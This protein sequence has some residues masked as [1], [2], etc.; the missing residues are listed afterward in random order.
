MGFEWVDPGYIF[1][2]PTQPKPDL[3][4]KKSAQ[5]QPWQEKNCLTQPYFY[6]NIY[7]KESEFMNQHVNIYLI[8]VNTVTISLTKTELLLC[9]SECFLNAAANDACPFL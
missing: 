4:Q 7:M 1:G 6:Q 8:L 5:T 3:G 2:G 9:K